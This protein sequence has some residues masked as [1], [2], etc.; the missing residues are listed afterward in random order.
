MRYGFQ[1]VDKNPAISVFM[2]L[3]SVLPTGDSVSVLLPEDEMA[4]R[5]PNAFI[6]FCRAIQAS[7]R[8]E[9]PEISNPDIYGLIGKM[10]QLTD[11]TM[12]TFYRD[13]AKTLGETFRA[14]HPE[15]E[16]EKRKKPVPLS[17]VKPPEPIRL[18]VL[19]VDDDIGAQALC[20]LL[21]VDER[22]QR[23]DIL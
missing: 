23:S 2:F 4:K 22:S 7:I 8:A 12:R 3:E 11:E 16:S 15:Y 6:L 5:P 14:T 9:N 17:A 18:K 10:W 21:Q 1:K 20:P 13:E 19:I